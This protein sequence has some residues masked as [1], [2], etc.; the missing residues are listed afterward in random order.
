MRLENDITAQVLLR[1]N[2]ELSAQNKALVEELR[3]MER[4][5][6][7]DSVTQRRQIPPNV[8]RIK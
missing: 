1:R 4:A 7:H 5:L 2:E 6:F 8:T 3:N